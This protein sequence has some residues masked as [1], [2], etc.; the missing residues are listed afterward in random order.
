LIEKKMHMARI[1]IQAPARNLVRSTI[2]NTT[3]VMPRP[4]VLIIRERNIRR[5]AAGIRLGLEVPG[6]VADHSE[7]AEVE[8]HEHADDVQLESAG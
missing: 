6:P 5:R 7:L 3:A 4:N 2:T 1:A 8:R